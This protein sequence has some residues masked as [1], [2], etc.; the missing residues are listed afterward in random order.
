MATQ[1][2]HQDLGTKLQT[3]IPKDRISI[4]IAEA[5]WV[6][7]S[8]TGLYD[9]KIDISSYS[10]YI[11]FVDIPSLLSLDDDDNI[12]FSYTFDRVNHNIILSIDEPIRCYGYSN[13]YTN[14]I[15]DS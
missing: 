2:R 5:D 6:L 8:S 3:L 4:R 15:S 9:Y 11:E 12:I 14:P 7:N 1:I 13:I 10:Y